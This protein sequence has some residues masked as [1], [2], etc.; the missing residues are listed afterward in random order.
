VFSLDPVKLAVPG[1]LLLLCFVLFCFTM[2]YVL[3]YLKLRNTGILFP[4]HSVIIKNGI[5]M[6]N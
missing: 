1:L 5:K 3:V 2:R 6:Y 4:F